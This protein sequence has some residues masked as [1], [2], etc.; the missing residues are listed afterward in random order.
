MKQ[1]VL[2]SLLWT[3]GCFAFLSALLNFTEGFEGIISSIFLLT[4]AIAIFPPTNNWV[5]LKLVSIYHR[6]ILEKQVIFV[7]ICL[8]LIGVL[9]T[10]MQTVVELELAFADESSSSLQDTASKETKTENRRVSLLELV[11]QKI[12]NN[13]KS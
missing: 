11:L 3:V 10:P 7:G 4:A 8:L 12:F 13:F 6:S 1:L 9:V 5:K 2:S